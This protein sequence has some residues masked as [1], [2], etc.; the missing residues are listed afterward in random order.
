MVHTTVVD[1]INLVF[2]RLLM[3]GAVLI[4]VNALINAFF[5]GGDTE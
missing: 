1:I 4:G 5:G 2:S 3:W